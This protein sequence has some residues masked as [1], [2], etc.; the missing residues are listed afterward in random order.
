MKYI[1]INMIVM[2]NIKE[3]ESILI[4][5]RIKLNKVLKRNLIMMIFQVIIR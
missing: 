4:F 1:K 5:K 3:K 2:T